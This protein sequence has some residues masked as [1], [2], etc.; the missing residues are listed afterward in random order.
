[1][2]LICQ[3]L[4][5]CKALYVKQVRKNLRREEKGDIYV[6]NNE[7]E[8]LNSSILNILGLRNMFAVIKIRKEKT[9]KGKMWNG[10]GFWCEY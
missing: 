7:Q 2:E 6:V 9:E 3:T 10:E 1:M 5:S 8:N 4:S